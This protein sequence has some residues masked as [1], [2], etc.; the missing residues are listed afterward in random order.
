MSQRVPQHRAASGPRYY[1]L[2]PFWG[3]VF[4]FALVVLI[5][6]FLRRLG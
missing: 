6:V 5:I 3:L 4:L 2:P 1:R